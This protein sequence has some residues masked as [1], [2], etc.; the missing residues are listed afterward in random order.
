MESVQVTHAGAVATVTINR[1]PLN[2]VS[3]GTLVELL[4]AFD[5]LERRDDTRCVVLTGAG[6]RAFCAGA[7]LDDKPK[8]TA[9]DTDSFRENGR[10]VIRRIESFPKPVVA[11][12]RG[13]A[14]GGGFGL[15]IACDVRIAAESAKFR[16]GDAYIGLVPSWGMSLVRLV[17]YIGRNRAM[18]LL[19]LGEDISATKAEAIGLVT[20][21]VP[22]DR[23]DAEIAA[24]S[25]RIAGGAPLVFRAVKEAM[26]SQYY[27]SPAAAEHV[28]THWAKSTQLTHDAQ[29]GIAA[30]KERRKPR[31]VGR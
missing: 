24:V 14:I 18:D 22:D 10:A 28:E 26:F 21:V 19:M 15:A 27:E 8:P 20:R 3:P 16:T 25:Q 12:I 23:F 13:W 5:G 1:P 17:H 7:N 30:F 9:E 4:Q 2:T 29:E 6:T 11:A 31:F